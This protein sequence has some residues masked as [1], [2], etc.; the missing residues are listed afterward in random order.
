MCTCTS[1]K[2]TDSFSGWL[3]GQM[4]V[5]DQYGGFA[6][7]PSGDPKGPRIAKAEYAA[8]VAHLWAGVSRRNNY[9]DLPQ[10]AQWYGIPAGMTRAQVEATLR[11]NYGLP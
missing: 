7:W 2:Y 6:N 5:P 1:C 10:G 4:G 9:N 11:R 3:H 8:H